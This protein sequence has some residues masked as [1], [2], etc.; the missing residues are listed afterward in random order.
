[1][2]VQDDKRVF[3]GTNLK[4]TYIVKDGHE[5]NDD[6]TVQLD[7]YIDMAI[8]VYNN[9]LSDDLL[10]EE[11]KKEEKKSNVCFNFLICI[12]FYIIRACL[13]GFRTNRS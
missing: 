10:K 13:A 1:M 5:T 11:K 12:I 2:R 7:K 9:I 4:E 3:K 8:Y 6:N